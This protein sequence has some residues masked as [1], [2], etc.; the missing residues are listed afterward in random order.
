M[1]KPSTT[2]QMSCGDIA[3]PPM[4]MPRDR[5]QRRIAQ[6]LRSPDQTRH[7]LQNERNA[8]RRD[9][10]VDERHAQA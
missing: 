5:E 8:Q 6:R 3:K 10:D 2:I 9:H 4:S 7:I 1:A